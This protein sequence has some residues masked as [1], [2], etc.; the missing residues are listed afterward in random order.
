VIK[1]E[2]VPDFVADPRPNRYGTDRVP[3][4]DRVTADS[5]LADE[6]VVPPSVAEGSTQEADSI[7]H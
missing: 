4:D 1:Q 5:T 6:E 2:I 7:Q 3:H